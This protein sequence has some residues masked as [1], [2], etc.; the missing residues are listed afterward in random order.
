VT[1]RIFGAGFHG[2]S[3]PDATS[4]RKSLLSVADVLPERKTC[5]AL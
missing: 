2:V 3:L 5:F 4:E 1:L